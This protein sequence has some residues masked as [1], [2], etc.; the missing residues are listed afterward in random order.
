[1]DAPSGTRAGGL[2]PCAY[3]VVISILSKL[4]APLVLQYRE[5]DTERP[6]GPPDSLLDADEQLI[7]DHLTEAETQH[8]DTVL[9]GHCTTSYRKV[10]FII[11]KTMT[12]SSEELDHVPFGYLVQRVQH[13]VESGRLESQG[14]LDYV[15]F[16]EVR[17]P[18]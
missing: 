10:A 5:L 15:R 6:E 13:L 14:D 8:V 4:R 11:G 16:S 9:L 7:V 17:I 3:G 2:H 18:N 1:M 12:P